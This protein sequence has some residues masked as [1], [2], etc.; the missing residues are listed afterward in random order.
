MHAAGQNFDTWNISANRN[1]TAMMIVY[2]EAIVCGQSIE[3][4]SYVSIL[5]EVF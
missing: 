5:F 4:Y 2:T 3:K 1:R